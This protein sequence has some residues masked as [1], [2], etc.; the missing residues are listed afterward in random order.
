MSR[1]HTDPVTHSFELR[2]ARYDSPDAMA[3]TKQAQQFYV[4]LYGGQDTTPFTADEFTPPYGG[5]FVGYLDDRPVA[6]GGWR[7]SPVIAPE[8]ATRPAELK[9]MF[10]HA[11]VRHQGLA[12]RLLAALEAAARE[13]GADWMILET[14]RPQVAATALYRRSG[15]VDIAP[16]GY[17]ADSPS[18]VSLGKRLR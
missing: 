6:M 14:G 12:R 1:P 8:G 4:E 5:F 17:Y 3:L 10:V 7:F 2:P 16:Y 13:A 15:Y 18:V 9:R 11:D